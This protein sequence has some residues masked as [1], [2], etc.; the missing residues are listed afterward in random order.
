MEDIIRRARKLLALSNSP[1]EHEAA[2]AASKLQE[3]LIRNQLAAED[4]A[5]HEHQEMDAIGESVVENGGRLVR[6]KTELLST[7]ADTHLCRYMIYRSYGHVGHTL[8]GRPVNTALA[9]ETFAY[10]TAT[11]DRLAKQAL[12]Q[13]QE[14]DWIESPRT[15]GNCFRLGCVSR[16]RSRLRAKK[17]ELEQAAKATG[18]AG[19]SALAM[20]NA[21]EREGNALAAYMNRNHPDLKSGRAF[22]DSDFDP[23]AYGR[24]RAAA[25]RIG[26]DSQLKAGRSTGPRA[27]AG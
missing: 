16:L 1:N 10:L 23:D 25:D 9:K 27:L 14:D 12:A 18:D 8:I 26:L 21:I 20:L 4:L 3:M 19:T 2:L 5:V 24:G 11:V 15:W 7:I 22:G 6:W 17:R 13:A